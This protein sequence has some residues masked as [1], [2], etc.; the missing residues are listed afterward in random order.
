MPV[1]GQAQQEEESG[2][3]FS[4]I[5]LELGPINWGGSLG[6][7][8]QW[9]ESE[10]GNRSR[11]RLD[12]LHL[13]AT[14]YLWQPWFAQLRG[15][16]GV[17]H[18]SSHASARSDDAQVRSSSDST[19]LTGD[20]GLT[21]FPVSRFPFDAFV[22]VG[23]SRTSGELTTTEYRSR[24]VGVRQGYRTV[25][26]R[27][28]YT[29]RLE[30]S[31][32][33]SDTFGRDT[34]EVIDGGVTHRLREHTFELNGNRSLNRAGTN[35]AETELKRLNGRHAY[36]RA[37]NLSVESLASYNQ[38]D[39]ASPAGSSLTTRVKQVTS[40]TTWRP[41]EGDSLYEEGRTLVVTGS[42]RLFALANDIAG[43]ESESQVANASLGASYGLSRN[44]RL[45]ASVTAT[46]TSSAGSEAVFT[47][48]NVNAT[49]TADPTQLGEVAYTWTTGGSASNSNASGQESRQ[50]VSAQASHNVTRNYELS[51]SS[52][53][54]LIAG[55]GAGV[56]HDT[57]GNVSGAS[58]SGATGTAGTSSATISS[59]NHNAGATWS[60]GDGAGALSHVSLSAADSR[61]FGPFR[62]AFQLVNFQAT[63]QSAVSN[64]S[65]WSGNLTVQG[66][67]QLADRAQ[68]DFLWTT[69]GSLT[70]VH[71]RAFGVPRLRFTALYTANAR[72][73]ASRAGGDIEAPRDFTSQSAEARFDYR[74]GKLQT[75]LSART[76]VIED[77]RNSMV[78]F[79]VARQ[80]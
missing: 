47:S 67:R 53:L 52:R 34:L 63:R 25:D 64:V 32:L 69:T 45:A 75:R 72:Q 71:Q 11:T 18:S 59:L 22:S 40:F 46:H 33:T 57:A 51:A 27:T 24:R 23:D 49:Y 16:F 55:Q 78:F 58:A 68:S 37:S 70:Y 14:S 73:V 65:Y 20:A 56:S 28:H 26:N 6:Q 74:I 7:E 76:A 80:L 77:R 10:G 50:T 13:N 30:Q 43:A 3:L 60:G 42:G 62:S 54:S 48:E 44:T 15:G 61:A 2:G 39:V 41:E 36:N 31:E 21:L 1:P 17:I 35:G 12:L 4:G 38:T 9:H 8:Y 19:S 79:S 5:R 66:T 29:A